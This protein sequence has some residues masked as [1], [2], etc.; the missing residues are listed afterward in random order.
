MTLHEA[1]EILKK[2]RTLST[3]LLEP[4]KISFESWLQFVQMPSEKSEKAI[5]R[6]IE[7]RTR[8]L[9]NQNRS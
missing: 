4:L 9:Q 8:K 5:D 1:L 7:S 2:T 3:D 6:L